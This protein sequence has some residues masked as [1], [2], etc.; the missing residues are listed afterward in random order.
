[1]YALNIFFL[2]K[3]YIPFIMLVLTYSFIQMHNGVKYYW[4][5]DLA[6][7]DVFTNAFTGSL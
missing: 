7:L 3:K 1:M 4:T 2:E 5:L 6:V